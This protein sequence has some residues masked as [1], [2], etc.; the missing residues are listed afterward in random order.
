MK[1]TIGILPNI[2]EDGILSLDRAY[3]QA[4]A[5]AGGIPI[6]VPY[7]DDLDELYHMINCLDGVL[8]TG[9][10]DIAP[11]YYGEPPHPKTQKPCELR[12]KLDFACFEYAF[13]KKKPILAICRGLQLA[14]A[15]L[16]GTLYQDLPA[17]FK[18]DISHIQQEGKFEAS[19]PVF[20][21]EGTP[22]VRIARQQIMA[23]NSF[24][25]QA[26][27]ELANGLAVMGTAE[28]GLIEAVYWTGKQYFRGYQWHPERLCATDVA[29]ENVFAE[30]I[31][32][33]SM[34]KG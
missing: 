2:N 4:I 31:T 23:S 26:I 21:K 25:H 32:F 7:G 19:H 28:D 24:H 20:V 14:N 15:A 11:S 34:S 9:G 29:N 3:V 10:G 6:I 17:Q 22:L 13:K 18:S 1:P 33:A 5:R 8:L 12:D 30:F 27:K 16:G